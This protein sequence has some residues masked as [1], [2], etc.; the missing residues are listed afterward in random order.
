MENFRE[1][2]E[3]MNFNPTE[4]VDKIFTEINNYADIATIVNDPITNTQKCKIAY[5]DLLNKKN[6]KV[7]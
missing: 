1:N 6:F 4:P 5:I 3:K 2:I 7:D